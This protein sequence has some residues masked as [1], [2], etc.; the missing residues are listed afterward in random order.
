MKIDGVIW[1]FVIWS[2]LDSWIFFFESF[3]INFLESSQDSTTKTIMVPNTVIAKQ[4][5]NIQLK[6]ESE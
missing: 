6:D 1:S 5:V 2:Q 3:H 4:N